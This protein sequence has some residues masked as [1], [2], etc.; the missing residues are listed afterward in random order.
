MAD[1]L[2]PPMPDLKDLAERVE[3]AILLATEA[4]RGQVD[5]AGKPYILHPLRVMLS[6]D[7]PAHQIA[8]VLHD[9]VEDC[10][11]E[12]ALIRHR[13][14]GDI[15]EA[16]DALTKREGETY[17]DFIVRC[18]RNEIAR[19]VKLADLTDN[20][21]LSR[22]PEVTAKDRQRLEKYKRAYSSLRALSQGGV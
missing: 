2:K 14:G 1:H 11:L 19:V 3:R 9:T 17:E 6:L 4:H 10:G 8:A 12:L 13:F 18:G 21:D 16:V 22:L 20:M 15:A 5:K 7:D